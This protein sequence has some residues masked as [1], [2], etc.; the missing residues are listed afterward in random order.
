[1]S[2]ARAR[3]R[4]VTSGTALAGPS[5]VGGRSTFGGT[6]VVVVGGTKGV[7]GRPASVVL[8]KRCQICAG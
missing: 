7:G 1:M 4:P 8:M 6:V 2:M 3:G 5:P